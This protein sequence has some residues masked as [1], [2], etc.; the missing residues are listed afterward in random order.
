MNATHVKA[1]FVYDQAFARNLG[2]VNEAEQTRL[3]NTC[4]ALPGLGGVGGAHLQALARLGVG[5]FR[6]ADPDTYEVVNFNRQMGATMDTVGRSKA[7]VMAEAVHAINP[8]ASVATFPDGITPENIGSFLRDVDV[9]VDGIEFFCVEARR[10]LYRECRKRNIPVV[11]AGPI[12]YGAAV[13]VFMPDAMSLEEFFNIDDTMTRA[14]QLLAFALGLAPGL[15][16]DVD[17]ARVDIAGEKGPAL[18]SACMLCAATAATE[19]LKLVC[20]RGQPSEAPFGTYYDP[21]RCRTVRLRQRPALTGSLRGRVLRW[22]MFRKFPAF[23]IMHE[24]ELQARQSRVA[25]RMQPTLS[26]APVERKAMR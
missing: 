24:R 21:Y 12:G 17:P 1:P 22:L 25:P 23:K 6:L 18:A 20:G 9:V 13:L 5:S 11:N 19:V 10:L 2:L 4:I 14:E 3:K 8:E 15:V 7:E 16:S 26:L